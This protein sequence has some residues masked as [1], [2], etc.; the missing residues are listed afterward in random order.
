MYIF[1]PY[2]PSRALTIDQ[3]SQHSQ[4]Q[5][6]IMHRSLPFLLAAAATTLAQIP[7]NLS[8]KTLVTDYLPFIS[9]NT[10]YILNDTIARAQLANALKDPVTISL[11]LNTPFTQYIATPPPSAAAGAIEAAS[12]AN[13]TLNS[14]LFQYLQVDGLHPSTSFDGTNLLTTRLTAAPFNLTTQGNKIEVFRNKIAFYIGTGIGFKSNV[15]IPVC[16]APPSPISSSY[17]SS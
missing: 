14:D 3:S 4:S 12:A 9:L 13:A 7:T 17:A 8:F 6:P 2:T 10:E 16:L 1:S 11:T 15:L 5:F